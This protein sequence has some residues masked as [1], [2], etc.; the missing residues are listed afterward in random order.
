MVR[1]SADETEQHATHADDD[2]QADHRRARGD[3][4]REGWRVRLPCASSPVPSRKNQRQQGAEEPRNRFDQRGR[5]EHQA[6][7]HQQPPSATSAKMPVSSPTMA[8]REHQRADEVPRGRCVAC[9]AERRAQCFHRR[10]ATCAQCGHQARKERDADTQ[11]NRNNEQGWSD[12]GSHFNIH[13]LLHEW[14]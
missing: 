3:C 4:P 7:E 13:K 11:D 5:N 12:N 6:D 9:L 2:R 1:R 14:I 10:D 8:T